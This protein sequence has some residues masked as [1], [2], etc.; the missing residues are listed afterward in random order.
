MISKRARS[1]LTK[2]PKPTIGT[3]SGRSSDS[4]PTHISVF[5]NDPKM[6]GG[7]PMGPEEA[8]RFIASRKSDYGSINRQVYAN[9]RLRISGVRD[10]GELES[11][12]RWV[13]LFSDKGRT[14]LLYE[15]PKSPLLQLQAGSENVPP[16]TLPTVQ[17]NPLPS[18]SPV[19][20]RPRVPDVQRPGAIAQSGVPRRVPLAQPATLPTFHA[21]RSHLNQQPFR[22]GQS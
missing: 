2:P 16:T 19:A 9:I 14:R 6:I 13:Q 4:L 8:E 22:Q 17:A 15:T 21:N 5:L 11:D 18:A 7:I 3:P 1:P 20:R 10:S 12:V